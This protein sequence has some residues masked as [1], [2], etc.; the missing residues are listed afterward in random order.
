MYHPY[1]PLLVRIK[2]VSTNELRR[3]CVYTMDDEP[4]S[5]IVRMPDVGF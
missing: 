5:N 2:S 3:H 1:D 4:L